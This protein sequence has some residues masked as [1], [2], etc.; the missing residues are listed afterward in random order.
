MD[1][2]QVMSP[3]NL[4]EFSSFNEDKKPVL[5]MMK[6]ELMEENESKSQEDMLVIS[7]TDF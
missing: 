2:Q 4:E 3:T 5:R 6:Q 7:A 1:K